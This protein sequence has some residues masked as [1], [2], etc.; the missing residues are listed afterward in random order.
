MTAF[1]DTRVKLTSR[2]S[3]SRTIKSWTI[4]D[5]VNK[6]PYLTSMSTEPADFAPS[7]PFVVARVWE[8][9]KEKRKLWPCQILTMLLIFN[10]WY[11]EIKWPTGSIDKIVS[12]KKWFKQATGSQHLFYS[13]CWTR[14]SFFFYKCHVS[15]ITI[16]SEAFTWKP[17]AHSDILSSATSLLIVSS[18]GCKCLH[19]NISF[20]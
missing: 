15:I 17:Q 9:E 12:G 16:G 1:G 2:L 6:S 18:A 3:P 13:R 4:G 8:N 20:T 7:P 11:L 10:Y 19:L 5:I 14:H